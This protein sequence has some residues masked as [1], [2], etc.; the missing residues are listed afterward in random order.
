MS[1]EH[2]NNEINSINKISIDT[3]AEMLSIK[4]SLHLLTFQMP[5]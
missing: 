1:N 2:M 5:I 4:E 3:N